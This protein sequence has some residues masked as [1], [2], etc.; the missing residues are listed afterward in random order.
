MKFKHEVV[1]KTES[2]FEFLHRLD[3]EYKNYGLK[4]ENK[5]CRD[6]GSTSEVRETRIFWG[7]TSFNP[8]KLKKRYMIFNVSDLKNKAHP[9]L[10]VDLIDVLQ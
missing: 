7:K 5:S 9:I 8:H 4:G 10:M 3:R 6:R 1:C 2:K